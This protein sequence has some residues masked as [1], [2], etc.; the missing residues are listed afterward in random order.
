[1]SLPMILAQAQPSGGDGPGCPPAPSNLGTFEDAVNFILHKR[2]SVSGGVCIG[3]PGELWDLTQTH[4]AVSFVAIAVAIVISVPIALWLGHIGKGEF[5][6]VSVSN[7]GRAVPSLA[8]LAFFVAFLGLG[9]VNI[10]VVLTL[11]A[12][13]PLLTN[14]YVGVR[15][16]DRDTVD[17][18]RGVGMTEAQIIRKIELPLS[19][20]TIFSG[21]R[22]SAVAVVATATIAPLG[23][24]DTLGLPIITPQTYGLAGELGA[25]IVV[26]LLTLILNVALGFLQRA[27]TPAGLK[28]AERGDATSRRF[29]LPI[30]WRTETR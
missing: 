11:L 8:L 29:S 21:L 2:E 7:V 13:P 23:N 15:Q 20:P 4:L 12:I 9:F 26:A 10:A 16:V 25:A 19:L 27:V 14:T 22:L 18:A 17:A 5:V 30:P 1:M 28:V 24:V 3:G 6:A